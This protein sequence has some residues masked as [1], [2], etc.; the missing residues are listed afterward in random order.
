MGRNA[1]PARQPSLNSTS[2]LLNGVIGFNPVATLDLWSLKPNDASR[3]DSDC[4]TILPLDAAFFQP[5]QFFAWYVLR[6]SVR[7]I[8]HWEHCLIVTES[9]IGKG[10]GVVHATAN[11]PC[12]QLTLPA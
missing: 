12:Q 1:H 7:R 9:R 3:F 6:L 8:H 10:N 5:L 4:S 11:P 2:C